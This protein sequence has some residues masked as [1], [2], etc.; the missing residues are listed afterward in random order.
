MCQWS[1]LLKASQQGGG[2]G[3]GGMVAVN[4]NRH[5]GILA[6]HFDR[7]VNARGARGGACRVSEGVEVYKCLSTTSDHGAAGLSHKRRPL[8]CSRV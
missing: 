4:P 6:A 8:E 3:G 7:N 5:S 2:E 1:L